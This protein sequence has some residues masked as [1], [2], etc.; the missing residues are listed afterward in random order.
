[1]LQ[2]YCHYEEKVLMKDSFHNA[3]HVHQALL[4]FNNDLIHCMLYPCNACVRKQVLL[5][6]IYFAI[7]GLKT[8][9]SALNT[10]KLWGFAVLV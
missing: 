10:G 5:L 3:Q 4:T 1:M 9:F 2:L 7:S 8:D 6:P